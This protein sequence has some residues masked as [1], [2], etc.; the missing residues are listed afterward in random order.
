MRTSRRLEFLFSDHLVPLVH[1]C[2]YSLFR[3]CFHILTVFK[4]FHFF[5]TLYIMRCTYSRC[6]R[7]FW[8]FRS[9]F[10]YV[11]HNFERT[12]PTRDL[13]N[14]YKICIHV[15]TLAIRVGNNNH[16]CCLEKNTSNVSFLSD[17]RRKMCNIITLVHVYNER[18]PRGEASRLSHAIMQFYIS[19]KHTIAVETTRYTRVRRYNNLS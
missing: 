3:I 1:F 8:S 12:I 5:F 11:W 17:E 7:A 2:P 13:H 16:R 15:G 19:I 14:V 6:I 4:K 10:V 9:F 18:R